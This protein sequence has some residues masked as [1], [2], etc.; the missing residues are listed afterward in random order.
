M[1]DH[2][3]PP[4]RRDFLRIG[5]AGALALPHLLAARAAATKKTHE[6]GFGRAKRCVLLFLT[7]GPPQHDTFDLKPD[8][9]A[10][11]RGELKPIA[12]SVGGLRFSE[13]CPRL[14]KQAHRVCVVR[15]VSHADTTHTS[16][17]YTMLTGV[18]HGLAN[19]NNIKLVRP[20]INDH[21]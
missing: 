11:I 3:G 21:P 9:P 13:L 18:K 20:S 7:G 19:T 8:A 14:A 12:T 16:A 4:T 10:E 5:S 2:L 17:G 1:F 6:V 15:S